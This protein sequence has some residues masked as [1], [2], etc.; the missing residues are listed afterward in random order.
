MSCNHMNEYCSSMRGSST[1][2]RRKIPFG[3]KKLPFNG[4]N[5]SD[6]A[7][8]FRLNGMQQANE[9]GC[10]MVTTIRGVY[11]LHLA[12]NPEKISSQNCSQEMYERWAV[13]LHKL[14]DM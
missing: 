5:R 13:L 2:I 6:V 11:Q 14:A 3:K 9:P 10:L 8:V 4:K 12:E 1:A 7:S